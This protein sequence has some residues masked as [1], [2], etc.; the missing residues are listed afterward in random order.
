MKRKRVKAHKRYDPRI[1]KKVDVG[2]YDRDQNFKE[3]KNVSGKSILIVKKNDDDDDDDEELAN[4]FDYDKMEK[5]MLK[6]MKDSIQE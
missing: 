4:S 5:K 2:S 6:L 1:N 3:Y